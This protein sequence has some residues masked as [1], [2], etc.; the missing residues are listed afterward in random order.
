MSPPLV[1]R[2]TGW[3]GAQILFLFRITSPRVRSSSKLPDAGP[4]GSRHPFGSGITAL[5]ALSAP[6][7]DGLG[8]LRHRL[9][10]AP[11]PSLAVGLPPAW[12][13]WG[14]PSCRPRRM[15]AE[16]LGPVLRWECSDVADPQAS[17]AVRPTYRFGPGLSAPL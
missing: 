8:F 13:T 14:L 7:Q 4:V 16:W 10:P 3:R 12:G 17:G 15:R 9:P 1:I 5:A 11:S 2:I 6:L